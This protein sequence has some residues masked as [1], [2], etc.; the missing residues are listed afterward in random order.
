[1]RDDFVNQ[2]KEKLCDDFVNQEKEKL[3]VNQKFDDFVNQEKEKLR[4]IL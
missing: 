2:E 1:M 3:F 4:G